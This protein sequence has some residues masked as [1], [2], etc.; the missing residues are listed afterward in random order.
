M[1]LAKSLFLLA[2][3]LTLTAC[4]V[5]APDRPAAPTAA[6]EATQRSPA[7]TSTAQSPGLGV[8]E[9]ASVASLPSSSAGGTAAPTMAYR[10]KMD[11]GSTRSV[12]LAGERFEPGDRVELTSD[13]RLMRR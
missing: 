11:D 5:S 10:V 13:G 7:P 4:A 8:V 6:G 9:S 3:S 12:L 1:N 2:Q